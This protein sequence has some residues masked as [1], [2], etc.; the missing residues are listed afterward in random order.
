MTAYE[1]AQVIKALL[2]DNRILKD[3]APANVYTPFERNFLEGLCRIG[4]SGKL[5]EL[6]AA[7]ANTLMSIYFKHALLPNIRTENYKSEKK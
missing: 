1:A 4:A 7:Q 3:R 6:T 5:E 2:T